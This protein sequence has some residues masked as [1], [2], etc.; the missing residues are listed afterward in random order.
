MLTAAGY[1]V[2]YYK[3]SEVDVHLYQMLPTYGYKIL[4]FRVHSALHLDS[5]TN[6]LTAPL[7]FFTSENYSKN[8]YVTDQIMNQ[9]DIVMYNETSNQKYFGINPN[10]VMG[11]MEGS[12]LN[13]IIILEGCNGLDGQ[14]RSG[15]MLQALVYK[16][17]SVIIGWNASVTA[18]HTDVGVED[19]LYALLVENKTV[20]EAVEETNSEI[21]PDPAYANELL[22]YP[23]RGAPFECGPDAGNYTVPHDPSKSTAKEMNANYVLSSANESALVTPLQLNVKESYV[24]EDFERKTQFFTISRASLPRN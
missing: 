7:D 22:Y 13:T 2:T 20:N 5:S 15:T 24:F 4:I 18:N 6:S 19:L 16:G 3:G 12:F 8:A 1:Q 23:S 14:G 21:A 11:D 9:L 17:A 10:F